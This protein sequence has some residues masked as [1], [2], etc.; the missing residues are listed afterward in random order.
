MIL[1][2]REVQDMLK[3]GALKEEDIADVAA[4]FPADSTV[5]FYVW[6]GELLASELEEVQ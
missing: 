3:S 5:V 2:E 4:L 1:L 6:E